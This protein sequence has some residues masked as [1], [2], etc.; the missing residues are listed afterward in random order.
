VGFAAFYESLGRVD[1]TERH[2]DE[3][4]DSI[5]DK[6]VRAKLMRGDL[7]DPRISFAGIAGQN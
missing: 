2:P 1:L 3:K 5:S 4:P 6:E 7:V